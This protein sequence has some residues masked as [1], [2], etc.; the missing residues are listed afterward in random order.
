MNPVQVDICHGDLIANLVK[1]HKPK[2]VLELGFGSGF[3]AR[4]ILAALDYN[5]S[6]ALT[7]SYGPPAT[8]TMVDNWLDWAEKGAPPPDLSEFEG[9]R[10]N[11]VE[12][13]EYRFV[14]GA[15]EK[16]DFIFS[17]A[18]HFN[19][20][21]WFDHVFDNLLNEKGILIYHDICESAP[22]NGE[23]WF[24]NLTHILNRTRERK[25]SHY[26]FNRDSLASERCWRGLLVIFK[27]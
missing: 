15:K 14:F 9:T 7:P 1:C 2:S 5:E 24:P 18:D 10:A 17:D 13:D 4:K 3:S 6:E 25:L 22:P 12:S 26:L 23:F 8:Y 19:A 16:W 21:R 27:N 11:I 20:Q